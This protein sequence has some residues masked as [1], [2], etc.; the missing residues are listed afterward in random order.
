MFWPTIPVILVLYFAYLPLIRT[1]DPKLCKEGYF[2]QNCSL[3]CRY[4]NYGA[5]CQEGCVCNRTLC[6]HVSGC[7]ATHEPE[8]TTTLLVNDSIFLQNVTKMKILYMSLDIRGKENNTPNK[9]MWTDMDMKYKAMLVCT[10]LFGILFIIIIIVYVKI[11]VSNRARVQYFKWTRKHEKETRYLNETFSCSD[12]FIG[13]NCEIKCR[14]PSFGAD[15][16]KRCM[17]GEAECSH[18]SGCKETLETTVELTILQSTL[19]MS[20]DTDMPQNKS[21]IAYIFSDSVDSFQ[22]DSK[23]NPS[24]WTL[25]DTKHKTL[26]IGIIICLSIFF[27]IM[28]LIARKKIPKYVHMYRVKPVGFQR[29]ARIDSMDIAS[30]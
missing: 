5:D 22:K 26:L 27:I 9:P 4:P 15:C 17:C 6:H 30:L 20:N 13:K 18:V 14:Y 28:T 2:G 8:E 3:P 7:P 1:S 21:K 11:T 25:L 16:Q 24:V 10:V 19:P 12:G 23:R 29:E